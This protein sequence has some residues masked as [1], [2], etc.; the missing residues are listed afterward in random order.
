MNFNQI[1]CLGKGKNTID[2][3]PLKMEDNLG[4]KKAGQARSS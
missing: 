4:K 3:H 2:L 1:S